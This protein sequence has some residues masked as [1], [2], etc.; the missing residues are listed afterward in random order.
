MNKTL[1]KKNKDFIQ[2]TNKQTEKTFS[3]SS[4]QSFPKK[5]K[6]KRHVNNDNQQQTN[7]DD[8]DREKNNRTKNNILAHNITLRK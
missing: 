5:T 8:D 1:R 2:R 6:D 4:F 3:L 7:N